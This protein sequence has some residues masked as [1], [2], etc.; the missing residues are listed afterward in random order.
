MSWVNTVLAE[1]ERHGLTRPQLLAH[2]GLHVAQL[3]HD[4]WP[5]DDITP[6]S[7]AAAA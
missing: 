7:R 4:R 2:A 5:I 1:A 3:N 6:L